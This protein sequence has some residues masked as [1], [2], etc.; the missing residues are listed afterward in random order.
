MTRARHPSQH[1]Y[2]TRWEG[3]DLLVLD[4]EAVIDRVRAREIQRVILVCDSSDAPSDLNF[5]VIETS[6]DCV[7]L[8]AETGIAGRVHFERQG[9]WQQRPCV[10]WVA[11]SRATLPRHLL[12]GVWLLR[13]NRPGYAR[14]PLS[15]LAPVIE[16]WPLE[17]P[18]SWE[19]RKWAR[20][21]AARSLPSARDRPP[22]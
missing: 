20:I 13:R 16:R 19:Q 3:D 7:I 6:S 12:P 5:A 15:E 17:G 21:V 8:P 2:A 14:V 9:F 22:K 18:Q 4:H 11:A 10:Y 1:H